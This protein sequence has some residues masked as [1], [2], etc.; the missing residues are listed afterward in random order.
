MRG[1]R[2]GNKSKGR[3]GR[4]FSGPPKKSF[5]GVLTSVNDLRNLEGLP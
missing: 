1:P 3:T 2:F 5:T 4:D